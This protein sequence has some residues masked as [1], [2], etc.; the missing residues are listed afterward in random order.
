MNY[1]QPAIRLLPIIPDSLL[2]HKQTSTSYDNGGLTA[3]WTA[4]NSLYSSGDVFGPSLKFILLSGRFTAAYLIIRKFISIS[5][6]NKILQIA[7]FNLNQLC[8]L[9]SYEPGAH[10]P[11]SVRLL[12][13]F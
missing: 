8:A 7:R 10:H 5:Y 12:L 9:A 1:Y 2:V 13:A 4:G 11:S 6:I 3:H